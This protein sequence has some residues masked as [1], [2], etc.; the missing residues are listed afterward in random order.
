MQQKPWLMVLEF[1]DYGDLRN[2]LKGC[3]SKGIRLT[4]GEQLNAAVQIAKGMSYIASKRM[5]HMDLAARNVLVGRNNLVKVADFGLTRRLPEGADSWQANSV[6]KLPI[7]WCA[8]EV[9][10]DRIFS[11]ASDV[12]A[13]GIV[14]WE[15]VT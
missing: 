14:M 12:W 9:L 3:E 6:M 8:I 5:I 7:K 10:D 13:F 11:E 1:L 15:I 2:V 4:Y